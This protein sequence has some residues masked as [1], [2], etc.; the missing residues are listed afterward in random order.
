MVRRLG[1]G[2]GDRL[3]LVPQGSA[4]SSPS[5]ALGSTPRRLPARVHLT[6]TVDAQGKVGTLGIDSLLLLQSV[7]VVSDP[8]LRDGVCMTTNAPRRCKSLRLIFQGPVPVHW[9][10]GSTPKRSPK[11]AAKMQQNMQQKCP[12]SSHPLPAM[13]RHRNNFQISMCEQREKDRELEHQLST[14]LRSA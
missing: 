14:L 12:K 7:V 8:P 4:Q 1:Q 3:P 9:P 13:D 6:I 10:G 2:H 11:N 5:S